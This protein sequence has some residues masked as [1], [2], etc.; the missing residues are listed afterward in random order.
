M[1]FEDPI[2]QFQYRNIKRAAA[3]V[4]YRNGALFGTVKPVSQR[5]RCGLVHQPQH[6][7][8]SHA[9]RVLRGLALRIVEVGRHSNHGM[10]HRRA[11]ETL[12]VAL[13]LAQ[14]VCRNLRRREAHF[15]KRDARNF[16]RFHVVGEPE[17]KQLQLVLNLFKTAPH[18]AFH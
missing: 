1:H 7:K 14:N 6:F 2:A 8:T 3:Q 17:R 11:E 13:E 12:R 18:Q 10:R 16:A 5:G 15:T 4:I 9:A